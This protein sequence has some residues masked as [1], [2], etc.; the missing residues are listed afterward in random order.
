MHK[1]ITS[2]GTVVIGFCATIPVARADLVEFDIDKGLFYTQTDAAGS[3][4]L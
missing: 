1:I 4:T 2:I 3:L